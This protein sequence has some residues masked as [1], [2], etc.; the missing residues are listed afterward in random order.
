MI[1]VEYTTY[2]LK[3]FYTMN[4]VLC[5][6]ISIILKMIYNNNLKEIY[7]YILHI[8]NIKCRFL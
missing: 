4:D 2:K 1:I 7:Y 6:N 5:V 3:Y 8:L